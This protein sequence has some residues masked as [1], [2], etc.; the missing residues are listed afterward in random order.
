MAKTIAIANQKGGVGK[1]TTTINL[2][3]SLAAADLRIL[4]VDL[5]PQGN[6][7]SGLGIDKNALEGTVYEVLTDG[8]D[9]HG[10]ICPTELE[11]LKVLPSNRD[12]IGATIELLDT[13]AREFRLDQALKGLAGEFDYI[14][15][16]CPP[17]LGI[18]TVNAL[19]TAD[20]LLIPIQSEFFALE[21]LSELIGTLNRIRQGLNPR[22]EI[23]GVL[24]T[25][26]DERLNLCNQIH[27]EVRGYFGDQVFETIVPRN[28]RLAESPGFGQPIL[29]YAARSK[30]ADSYLELAHEILKQSP[31][32][33]PAHEP[34]SME[35]AS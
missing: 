18:L 2:G 6:C 4:V 28:V 1:T 20:S 31:A 22:L 11:T 15:I 24:L 10:I 19:V 23:E 35:L 30:G 16:D 12:L 3:A 25:M 32:P 29:L 8:A 5:D 27:Q 13:P 21:G 9:P 33:Q 34:V 26:H 17:A 7:T 14:L